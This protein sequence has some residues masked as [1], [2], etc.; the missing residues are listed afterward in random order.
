MCS[1][2][3]TI[4]MKPKMTHYQCREKVCLVCGN[5]SGHRGD[6]KLTEDEIKLIKEHVMDDFDPKDER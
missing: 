6:R 5:E 1:R 2:L 3:K 4:R